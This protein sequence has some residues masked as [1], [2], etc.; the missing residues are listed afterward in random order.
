MAVS[1]DTI[2]KLER[3]MNSQKSRDAVYLQTWKKVA[4]SIDPWYGTMN[5]D[6]E[7]TPTPATAQKEIY[8]ST[9]YS[10]S[11]VFA[12]GLQ[13]YVCSSQSAFFSLE[14]EK[15]YSLSEEQT[16]ELREVLQARTRRMYQVMAQ[17]GFYNPIYSCFKSFGDL[18]AFV[19]FGN[20]TEDSRIIYEQ[21]PNYQCIPLWNRLK[22]CCDTIFRS[23]WLTRY[24]A[25]QL[26]GEEKLPSYMTGENVDES[27]SFQFWELLCPRDR[28]GFDIGSKGEWE[29]LD[30]IWDSKEQRVVFE[31]G[32]T[33]QRFWLCTFSKIDDGT[34][35]GVGGPG[36]RQFN[37]SLCLQRMSKD[38]LTASQ[39]AASPAIM[40]SAGFN[41]KI[42]PAAFIDIPAGASMAP[43]ELGQDLS[44]TTTAI[45]DR[46]NLAKSDY[47]VDYFL[48]L[49]QYTGNINTA[50]M[51][52]GLQNEQLKMM[53]HFLDSLRTGFF[54]PVID[55]T[56]NTMGE[57]G[58]FDDGY[59]IDYKSLQVDFVSPLYILQKQAVSLE[60]T[61]AV[62]NNVLPYLQIDPTLAYYIDFGNF[63]SVL[64]DASNADVRI[65]RDKET[66]EQMIQAQQQME[67]EKAAQQTAIQQQD[68]DTREYA[69][70]TKAPE[71]GSVAAN[72]QSN[73]YSNLK[74]K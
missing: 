55:W 22:G 25:Q 16:T 14:P 36:F 7:P 39:Y 32:S 45:A 35:W 18:S 63:V 2:T 72:L 42:A 47:F 59:E 48:M 57:L 67:A 65:I 71:Q 3:I 51:A 68:A 1:K 62:M 33:R 74:L 26:F 56:W 41:A 66:A 31:G 50:T 4:D 61:L 29:H 13:G 53:T 34:A 58:Y 23:L 27:K 46:R 19:M 52:Q 43:L 60:P 6:S 8:D 5:I 20:V 28:F 10:Y 73:K 11:N 38:L 70:A 30:I 9:I 12:M 15:S 17:C 24:E 40:K 69:A 49:S 44:W 21:V 54:E 64:R 37:N